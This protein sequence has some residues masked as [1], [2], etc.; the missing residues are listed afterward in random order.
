MVPSTL[1]HDEEGGKGRSHPPPSRIP[2]DV[3]SCRPASPVN[4]SPVSKR[5][6][7]VFMPKTISEI[8]ASWT[9][10]IRGER[11]R[12]KAG[13][14]VPT[15]EIS[16]FPELPIE[17]VEQILYFAIEVPG[18]AVVVARV[19]RFIHH[20]AMQRLYSIV[21]V[22]GE[23][24]HAGLASTLKRNPD[25]ASLIKSIVVDTFGVRISGLGWDEDIAVIL[26]A[27]APTL[28]DLH[29][30]HDTDIHS[31]YD[32]QSVNPR[33]F[34]LDGRSRLPC[35]SLRWSNLTHVITNDPTQLWLFDVNQFPSLTHLATRVLLADLY[36]W[37]IIYKPALRQFSNQ[38]IGSPLFL[39]IVL[40][41]EI[42]P[43]AISDLS[44]LFP[45]H[46]QMVTVLLP[47]AF[48][49]FASGDRYQIRKKLHEAHFT[50]AL[51]DVHRCEAGVIFGGLDNPQPE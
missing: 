14:V 20:Q 50:G 44:L 13:Q 15:P 24:S 23:P 19:G 43:L 51:W 22:A 5:P 9:R 27:T 41:H 11:K 49:P 35:Y 34:L 21:R 38:I 47:E 12:R 33:S 25:L 48:S 30:I 7:E 46:V 40:Q 42:A 29:I 6:I 17:V 39:V 32:Y 16:P 37:H 36:V 18:M 4:R 28:E 2:N 8:F 10:R 45:D 31:D 26:R 3:D 1:P